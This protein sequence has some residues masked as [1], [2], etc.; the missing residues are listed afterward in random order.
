MGTVGFTTHGGAAV[1]LSKPGMR[2]RGVVN[3][4]RFHFATF[5]TPRMSRQWLGK[6]QRRM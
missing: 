4:Y 5:S 2:V 1:R 3:G 6:V